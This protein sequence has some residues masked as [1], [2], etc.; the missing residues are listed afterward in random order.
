MTDPYTPIPEIIGS[1]PFRF[2]KSE[3]LPGAKL[4]YEKT[5]FYVARSEPASGFS[6]GK[7]VKVDR[8]EF[9]I[10]PDATVA[11]S[12]LRNGEVDF[13]DSPS[14]DVVPTVANDAN[15]V[16]R[17]VWPIETY[18]VLRPTSIQRPENLV[19]ARAALSYM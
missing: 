8:V 19:K 10:I 18:A 3:Y 16:V 4:V 1:G 9:I 17:E 2:V 7:L 15:I 11:I 5:P 6:G 12:A 13:I 14:L